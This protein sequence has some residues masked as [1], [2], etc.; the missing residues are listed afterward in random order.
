MLFGE[1]FRCA[2]TNCSN[3]P[4]PLCHNISIPIKWIA[5]TMNAYYIVYRFDWF[6]YHF[7]AYTSHVNMYWTDLN[8]IVGKKLIVYRGSLLIARCSMLVARCSLLGINYTIFNK[9]IYRRCVFPIGIEVSHFFGTFSST[10]FSFYFCCFRY[11]NPQIDKHV[12]CIQTQILS[13]TSA[14]QWAIGRTPNDECAYR[15]L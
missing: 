12:L 14:S 11:R 8:V 10:F 13:Q 3:Y 7:I 4:Q 2:F 15:I 5:E 6:A 9:N 1:A